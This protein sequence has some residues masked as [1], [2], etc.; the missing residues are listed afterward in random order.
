MPKPG[1]EFQKFIDENDPKGAVELIHN[2]YMTFFTE[3]QNGIF[4][5][6]QEKPI[7][8]VK[9][10]YNQIMTKADGSKEIAPDKKEF[11][12][13]FMKEMNNVYFRTAVEFG[14]KREQ[15]EDRFKSGEFKEVNLVKDDVNLVKDIAHNVMVYTEVGIDA[16][17][18]MYNA[19]A[20]ALKDIT[21]DGMD[22]LKYNQDVIAE[23][24]SDN[25]YK[26]YN[27]SEEQ[28]LD[29]A[30][31]YRDRNPHSSI[32][33][34]VIREPYQEG[35]KLFTKVP[36]YIERLMT[37][38]TPEELDSYETEIYDQIKDTRIYIAIKLW[39]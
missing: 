34:D 2:Y 29:Y 26:E 6:D 19:M 23:E 30:M 4:N 8:S 27:L 32:G 9:A 13:K 3:R 37:I 16:V 25:V 31:D 12:L 21:I 39:G 15:W 18:E 22:G 28:I 20:D 11:L 5:E 10:F 14:K 35:K 1:E 17:P 36:K 7:D 38:N 33:F 24:I